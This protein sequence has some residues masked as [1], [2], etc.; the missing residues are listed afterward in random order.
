MVRGERIKF[1]T[2][3]S[4]ELT[5]DVTAG[6]VDVYT[7]NPLNGRIQAIYFQAGDWD[8]TGSIV[9]SVSGLGTEGTILNIVSGTAT[10][11]YLSEDWVVFPRVES[12]LTDGVSAS[13]TY[14][15]D[16]HAEI[17]IWS[18]ARVQTGIVGTGS[19]A[20]GLTIVY[21]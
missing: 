4:A 16:D 18:N 5:G 19:M 14:G 21:I 2:F 6:E 15:Y 3:Q 20:S 13:G 11:H 7:E 10:G 17:P 8:A 1:Y 12:V 9:I